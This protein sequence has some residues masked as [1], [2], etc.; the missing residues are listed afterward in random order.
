MNLVLTNN[1]KN[2]APNIQKFSKKS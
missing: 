1:F 2:T